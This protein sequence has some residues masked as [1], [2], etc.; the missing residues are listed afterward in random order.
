MKTIQ[1]TKGYSTSVDDAD[2]DWLMQWKWCAFVN[3]C[4]RHVVYAVRGRRTDDEEK[5]SLIYMHRVLMSAGGLVVDHKDHDGLNNQRSNLRLATIRLNSANNRNGANKHGFR[6]VVSRDKKFR[7]K[8][9]IDRSTK[10]IGTFNTPE[11]AAR[12]YDAAAIKE[13]GEFAKLNFP[14]A[15]LPA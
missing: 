13:F 3:N 15:P 11:E 4:A 9:T 5:T 12:A 1:L 8:I 2:Y 7:A 10:S 6:G 14:M